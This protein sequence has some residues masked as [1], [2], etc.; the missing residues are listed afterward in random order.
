MLRPPANIA[1]GA[2][3]R[4]RSEAEPR[5]SGQRDLSYT[6]TGATISF[7]M[8]HLLIVNAY[9]ATISVF[10]LNSDLDVTIRLPDAHYKQIHNG[11][12]KQAKTRL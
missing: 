3:P 2:R 8:K 12:Y 9:S 11:H 5:S 7:I 6:H 4:E 10:Q 1:R